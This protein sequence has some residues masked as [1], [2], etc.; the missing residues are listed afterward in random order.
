MGRRPPPALWCLSCRIITLRLCR[1]VLCVLHPQLYFPGGYAV[2]GSGSAGSCIGNRVVINADQAS[3]EL[4][5]RAM[6]WTTPALGDV[7]ANVQNNRPPGCFFGAGSSSGETAPVFEASGMP[8][9]KPT[10]KIGTISQMP[11]HY[12]VEVDTT[13]SEVIISRPI[14]PTFGYTKEKEHPHS[15]GSWLHGVWS[16]R[17]FMVCRGDVL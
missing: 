16:R 15:V 14:T 4:A 8:Y 2:G 11:S 13:T 17:L 12:C 7:P 5:N 1:I 9:Y 6:S 3:C 10:L